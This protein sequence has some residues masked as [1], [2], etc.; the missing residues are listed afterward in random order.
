[1]SVSS[2]ESEDHWPAVAMNLDSVRESAIIVFC[3]LTNA[4]TEID[5]A[6][7]DKRESAKS[8][9]SFLSGTGVG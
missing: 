9:Q 5:A 8:D 1:L 4:T 6:E 7:F 3:E 2:V